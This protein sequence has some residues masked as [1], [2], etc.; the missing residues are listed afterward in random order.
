MTQAPRTQH[1]LCSNTSKLSQSQDWKEETKK[2]ECLPSNPGQ[3]HNTRGHYLPVCQSGQ[4]GEEGLW[5]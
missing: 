4:L 1:V 2:Q 5:S 3:L